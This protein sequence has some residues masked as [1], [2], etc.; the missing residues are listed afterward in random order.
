MM[1]SALT[2]AGTAT[3][4]CGSDNQEYKNVPVITEDVTKRTMDGYAQE[5]ATAIGSQLTNYDA[6]SESCS[7]SS[8]KMSQYVYSTIANGQI[9]V[10]QERHAALLAQLRQ[11]WQARGFTVDLDVQASGKRDA[12]LVVYSPDRF[13]IRLIETTPPTAFA[14]MI[15]SPCRKSPTPLS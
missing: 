14:L 13:R 4:G 9:F 12:E 1:V 5:I 8:D 3:T 7:D 15:S 2:V 10:P 6:N 11:Q